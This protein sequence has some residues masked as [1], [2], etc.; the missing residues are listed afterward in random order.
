MPEKSQIKSPF[1]LRS[2]LL[3]TPARQQLC[4]NTLSKVFYTNL[5]FIM[6]LILELL[7]ALRFAL[8]SEF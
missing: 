1:T 8:P 6:I 2:L 3:V 5:L 4:E 7:R